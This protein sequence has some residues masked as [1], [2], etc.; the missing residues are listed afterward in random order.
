MGITDGVGVDRLCTATRTASSDRCHYR[1][2]KQSARSP[3]I[4]YEDWQHTAT[5]DA[6]VHNI[7]GRLDCETP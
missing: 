3:T 4:L 7:Q 1:H 2:G 6:E 5:L